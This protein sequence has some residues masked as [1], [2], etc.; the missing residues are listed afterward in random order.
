MPE[1]APPTEAVTPPGF[2]QLSLRDGSPFYVAIRHIVGFSMPSGTVGPPR[3][4]D[5]NACI[6]FSE[7]VDYV[8]GT[9]PEIAKLI[10]EAGADK[11]MYPGLED[12][13]DRG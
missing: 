6:Q 1:S 11:R 2:I 13:F 12:H 9:V 5:I 8:R 7:D 10:R 4:G 3:G